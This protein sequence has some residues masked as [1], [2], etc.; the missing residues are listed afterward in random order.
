ML[1]LVQHSEFWQLM[2]EE[3]GVG[4]ARSVARDQVVAA[5]GGRTAAEA[6][7]AHVPPRQVWLALCDAMD[8]PPAYRWGRDRRGGIDE[9]RTD[10]ARTD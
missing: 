3:F 5:L 2:D 8:V 7:A 10:G 1:A 9:A 4:Y 6:L